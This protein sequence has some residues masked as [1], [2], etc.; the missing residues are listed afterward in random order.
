MDI[1]I[2]RGTDVEGEERI[3]RGTKRRKSRRGKGNGNGN[4]EEKCEGGE[5]GD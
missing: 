1:K 4:V 2:N 3:Y 5:N